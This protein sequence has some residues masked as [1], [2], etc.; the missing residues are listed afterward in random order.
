MQL[1]AKHNEAGKNG[2]WSSGSHGDRMWAS[3]GLGRSC[4]AALA[5]E[6]VKVVIVARRREVLERTA[7]EIR[8]ATGA[9]IVAVAADVTAKEGRD[10]ILATCPDPDILVNNAGGPPPGDFRNWDRDAWIKALDANMLA[11]IELMKS[12]IDGMIARR[13]GRIVN[14]TSH[15]VKAPIAML[16]L[17]N[18]ARS[19][20][21]G[22]VAGLARATAEHNVTINNLLPG[23]F[24][25]DRLKSNLQALAN[26]SKRSLEEVTQQIK[27]S[28]PSRRFG[29]PDEFGAACAFLCSAHAGY[30]TGQNILIDGGAFPGTF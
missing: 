18:G 4:A 21:T 29:H 26:S 27:S 6:G 9:E 1:D 2:L 10:T 19:G 25:T 22:F 23:T 20:L 14:I 16:G 5:V 15:A 8:S 12:T 7:A 11:P 30:I 28:N 24:D 17:S 13:F 3:M